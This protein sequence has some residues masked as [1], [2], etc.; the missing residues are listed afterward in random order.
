[1]GIANTL[2]RIVL[3]SAIF[4]LIFGANEFGNESLAQKSS[5]DKN[6]KSKKNDSRDRD[7]DDDD[8]K[9]GDKDDK[10]K[11]KHDDDDDRGKGKIKMCHS[12]ET[13]KVSLKDFFKHLRHGDTV[14]PC[15][16][17]P[18]VVPDCNGLT[19]TIVGTNKKDVLFGTHD[20]DVIVG[21]GGDDII[22]GLKGDDVICGGDGN[23]IIFGGDG[24]DYIEGEKDKD[25]LFGN[26]DDDEIVAN[27]GEKDRINGGKHNDG[28]TCI[29]DGKIK[30][31]SFEIKE[32]SVRNCEKIIIDGEYFMIDMSG[33]VTLCHIPPGNEDNAHTIMVSPNAVPA[34]LAH[35][36]ELGECDDDDDRGKDK[37]RDDDDD[38]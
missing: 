12:G 16:V 34:H 33:K 26:D 21:L 9:R 31:G 29:I 8:K 15:E 20:S 17:D 4:G 35:G 36:D 28:D 14:G 1:M 18:P 10:K 19:P 23:D 13:I 32:K 27:D 38:D 37:D 7:N 25:I 5:D 30:N 22:F 11:D 2:F 6:E 3:F 24:D